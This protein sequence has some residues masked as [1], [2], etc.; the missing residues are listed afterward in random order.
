MP[1][2][3]VIIAGAY[4]AVFALALLWNAATN[5]I[6]L[7]CSALHARR[8]PNEAPV[9]EPEIVITLVHGTW[10]R[11]AMWTVPGSPLCATLSGAAGG[12]VTFQRFVWSGKNSISARRRAVNGLIAH[13]QHLIVQ[14]P[15]SRHYIVAH[16]HGGNI[17]FQGLGRSAPQPADRRPHLPLDTIFDGSAT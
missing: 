17:A 3:A 6:A 8:I 12:P 14:W 7:T 4:F 15:Q 2:I 11:H 1:S 5:I 13:L 9:F 16:S 10:A